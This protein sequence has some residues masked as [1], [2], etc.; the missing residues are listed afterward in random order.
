MAELQQT[1]MYLKIFLTQIKNLFAHIEVFLYL[2]ARTRNR[3]LSTHK[4][5]TI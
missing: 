5:N 4:N 3:A 2:C 1:N